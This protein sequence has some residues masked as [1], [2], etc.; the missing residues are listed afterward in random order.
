MTGGST[1][2][3]PGLSRATYYKILMLTRST[4]SSF[5]P[6]K[7]VFPGGVVQDVDHSRDWNAV[8][9]KVLGRSLSDITCQSSGFQHNLRDTWTLPP[10]VVYRICAIRETFEESGLLLA[11]DQ[12]LPLSF[13]E[14]FIVS[15]SADELTKAAEGHRQKVD[16]NP[17][18]F[19]QMCRDLGVVPNIWA[20]H[21][22]RN[23]LTPVFYKVSEPPAKPK[24][25]N[26][27]FYLCC[28]ECD[29]S[30]QTLADKCETT[31]AEVSSKMIDLCFV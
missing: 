15:S 28:V 22:W 5:M 7:L 30:P 25:F 2:L 26:T 24:R 18:Y 31:E 3:S 6:S 1:M 10:D 27:M 17:E 29:N 13:R 14:P 23:W 21:E 20:L 11:T 8:F 19:L 9:E 4:Q 12:D 16:E